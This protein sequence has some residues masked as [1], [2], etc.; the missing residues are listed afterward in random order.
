MGRLT[1]LWYL[2]ILHGRAGIGYFNTES[3][4]LV[5]K[6]LQFLDG[7]WLSVFTTG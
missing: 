5:D 2:I 4:L 3:G 6:V 1:Y 7:L